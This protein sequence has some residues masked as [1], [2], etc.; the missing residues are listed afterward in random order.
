MDTNRRY[1]KTLG[2]DYVVLS[3]PGKEVAE[4]YGVVHEGRSVPERWTFI[5]A[6]DGR[7]LDIIT[8]VDTGSHGA[9]IAARLE[10]LGVARR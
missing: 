7:I 4:A 6:I 3:D 8:E 10:E 9:Q 5:I 2:L 1:A